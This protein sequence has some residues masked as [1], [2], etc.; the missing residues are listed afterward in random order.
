MSILKSNKLLKKK[1][2]INSIIYFS[3]VDW[4]GHSSITLF[5]NNCPFRCCYCYNESCIYGKKHTLIKTIKKEIFKSKKYVKSIVFLG[6]EATIQIESLIQL[7]L[8]SKKNNLLVGLHTNGYYIKNI[9]K[10]I[11]LGIID[12]YFVDIKAPFNEKRYRNIINIHTHKKKIIKNI[13]ESIKMIDLS[14]SELELKTTLFPN[15]VGTKNDIIKISEWIDKYILFKNKTTFVLQQ[16][17]PNNTLDKKLR[18]KVP[19]TNSQIKK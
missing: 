1:C 8:F 14:N 16:G 10:L 15:I 7:A 3:T 13:I 11:K 4:H 2:N 18:K 19:Y 5:F 17:I 12:K 9:K 6:G